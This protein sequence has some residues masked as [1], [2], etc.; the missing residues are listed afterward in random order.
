MLMHSASD[1][2]NVLQMFF[3]SFV[4]YEDF[5]QT[6]D[7]KRV[8]EG[9]QDIIH[10]PHECCLSISQAKKHDQPLK[11]EFSTLEGSLSYTNLFNRDLV[12][13]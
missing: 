13:A 10:H 6:Y 3:P 4:E 5:I 1:L 8:Y 11:R 2:F 12:V 9:P 7:H